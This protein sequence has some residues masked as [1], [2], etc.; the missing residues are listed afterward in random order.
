MTDATQ[1]DQLVWVRDKQ[2]NQFL[3]P[4]S[5]LRDPNTVSEDEKKNCVDDASRLKSQQDVPGNRKV[6]FDEGASPS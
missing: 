5:S 3:C 6:P 2:D 4:L 1:T